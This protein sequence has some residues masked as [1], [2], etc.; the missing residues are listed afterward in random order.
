MLLPPQ[1]LMRTLHQF[2]MSASEYSSR[3]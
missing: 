1:K 3:K 2:A